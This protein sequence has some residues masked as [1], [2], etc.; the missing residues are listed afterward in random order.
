MLMM[1][2]VIISP[3]GDMYLVAGTST[4]EIVGSLKQQQKNLG[5]TQISQSDWI[6]TF[7]VSS[8]S[9]SKK[10]NTNKRNWSNY[11]LFSPCLSH[12]PDIPQIAN[13][14]V[15]LRFTTELLF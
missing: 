10:N 14:L 11:T 2:S 13:L 1:V 9:Q 7:I 12:I 6:V 3:N 15:T 4:L 8:L 5:G